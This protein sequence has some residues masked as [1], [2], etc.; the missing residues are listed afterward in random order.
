[1]PPVD[2]AAAVA[3]IERLPSEHPHPFELMA[4]VTAPADE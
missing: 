2:V 4:G 3:D 1:V